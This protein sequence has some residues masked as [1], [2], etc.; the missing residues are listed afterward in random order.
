MI[1]DH[2]PIEELTAVEALG[3][4]E[5]EDA[6]LLARLRAEHGR[7]EECRRIEDAYAETA[8]RLAFALDP[9]PVS[10]G[11][12][13]EILGTAV[14][15]RRVVDLEAER[16]R[17]GP[18]WLATA[19]AAAAALLAVVAGGALLREARTP[20]VSFALSGDLPG[21][22][23][24]AYTPGESGI[25]LTAEGLEAPPQ[26]SVYELWA[27]AGDTPVSAACFTPEAG[28][29]DLSLAT[30]INE[31]DVMAITV[32]SASCPAAPT[33]QPVAVAEIPE[34]A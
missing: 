32:E 30:D 7:C 10:G 21:T 25:R 24:V 8:G 1:R 17:R 16:R 9:E 29:V 3:G 18:S 31:S 5:P 33:T 2:E 28:A 14:P 23:R 6:E 22:V 11:I 12:A 20:V 27:I 15:P 34:L 26:D 13:S 19:V 4:L